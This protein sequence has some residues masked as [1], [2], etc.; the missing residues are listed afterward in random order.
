MQ[1]RNVQLEVTS[2]VVDLMPPPLSSSQSNVT[3]G[4][5]TL[6][7]CLIESR[8]WRIGTT[9]LEGRAAGK[10]TGLGRECSPGV[11][12]ATAI[13]IATKESVRCA[14]FPVHGSFQIRH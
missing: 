6:K 12:T 13:H 1:R 3:L 9:T 11:D 7:S 4:L 2:R 8:F 5:A 14:Y 10:A